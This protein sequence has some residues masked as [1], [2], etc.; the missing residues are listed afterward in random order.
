MTADPAARLD[1]LFLALADAQRRRVLQ[2]LLDEGTD[3][4]SAPA[5]AMAVADEEPYFEQSQR[6]GLSLAVLR[7]N[8]R[9]LS[10]TG[11][12]EYHWDDDAVS[13]AADLDLVRPF[14]GAAADFEAAD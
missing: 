4:T 9:I 8:L 6:D 3:R 10:D 12:V 5:L 2:H 1:D 13:P 14:L 11:F 7:R